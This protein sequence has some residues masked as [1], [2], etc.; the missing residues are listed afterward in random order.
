MSDH[1]TLRRGV[2]VTAEELAQMMSPMRTD[3]VVLDVR[4]S[5]AEPD[6]HRA[7][8][9]GHIPGAHFVDL[10]RDLAGPPGPGGRH[11]LPDADDLQAAARRWGI[12]NGDAVVVYDDSGGTAAARAWW[13]LRWGGLSDVRILDGGLRAWSRSGGILEDGS[14]AVAAGGVTLS[15]GHMPLTDAEGAA[16]IA[17]RGVLLDARDR[18]RYTGA[19]EPV[20]PVAGHIPGARSAPTIEN[21]HEDQTFLT[22]AEMREHFEQVGVRES[23]QV[24]VYCGSG[25]TAAHEVAALNSIGIDAALYPGSW[26]QWCADSDRPVATGLEP[27]GT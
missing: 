20:D 15:P 13:L 2:L 17:R 21:L 12:N 23:D 18:D 8:I 25:V 1:T 26:S 22:D 24:A 6:G 27:S 3:L 14:V 7:Y 9:A 19:R 10:A 5:L 16:D 11:P 4:W